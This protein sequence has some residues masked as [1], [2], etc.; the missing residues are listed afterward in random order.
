MALF[1]K[2]HVLVFETHRGLW[3][4]DGVF[5][6]ILPPGRYEVPKRSQLPFVERPEIEVRLVDIR[7]RDLTIKGQEILTSDKVA[8]R[9]SIMVQFKVT[10][11]RA[12]MI[13]VANYEERLYGDVQLAA[14]R[15]LA[16]MTLEEIL[17]NR[18]RLSEDISG[19]LTETARGYGVSILRA[20]V[21]DLIFPGDVQEIMN[22]VLKAERLSQAQLVEAKSRSAIQLIESKTAA[23]R[24]LV[25]AETKSKAV[26]MAAEAE[27]EG[28]RIRS[29]SELAAMKDRAAAERETAAQASELAK[30]FEDHPSLLRLRELAALQQLGANSNARIYIGFDKHSGT[31]VR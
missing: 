3:F 24:E 21:K 26:R 28:L 8:I 27:A 13:E 12:A 16:S 4:E 17:T 6:K 22:R 2:N 14:R 18:N 30:S 29:Q 25:E 20:D 23:D 10:D 9:V 11:P 19:D 1:K 31:D 5:K 7:E 15:S